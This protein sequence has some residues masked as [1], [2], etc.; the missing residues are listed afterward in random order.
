MYSGS[1]RVPCMYLNILHTVHN[2]PLCL[3]CQAL[4]RTTELRPQQLRL[5]YRGRRHR[6]INVLR[7]CTLK[8]Q[9]VVNITVLTEANITIR[10]VLST[11]IHGI[12]LRG[13][14]HFL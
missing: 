3:I 4:Q 11:G 13:H 10:Y 6:N 7:N 14:L 12:K 9:M 2:P 5:N 1:G 8:L